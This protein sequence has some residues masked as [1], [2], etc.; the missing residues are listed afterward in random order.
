MSIQCSSYSNLSR[1]YI[2]KLENIFFHFLTQFFEEFMQDSY[3]ISQCQVVIGHDTFNLVEFSQ[4]GCIQTLIT[5]HSVN[6][7]ILSGT[8]L[9]L[10]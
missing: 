2:Y 1:R 7:E 8:E 3:E 5:K 9:L 4:V 6:R 10:K